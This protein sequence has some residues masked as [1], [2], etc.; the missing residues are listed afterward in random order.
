VPTHL[1][2]ASYPT[3][4][5]QYL[6][7][8]TYMEIRRI[9]AMQEGAAPLAE[10]LK[11]E[12]D[13]GKRVLWLV[14]GGSNI[15]VSAAVM[16]QISAH[17]SKNVS[18]YLTD[19]RYGEID[20]PDSNTR[21]LRE[22]GFDFKDARMVNVLAHGLGL[23]QTCEQYAMSI[24]AAFDAAQIVIAQMG[25]GP[26]GHIC[27]ILPGSPAVDSKKLVV[28]YVTETFTRITLTPKALRDHVDAAYVF[29]FGE[30]KREA[31]SNL[32]KDLPLDT[33]PAQIL[34]KLP[35]AIVYNDQFNGETGVPTT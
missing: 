4:G 2:D 11:K 29:A 26:D 24:A 14:P 7:Y 16:Q 6:V 17:Q 8:Y 15:P 10:R 9:S 13:A 19:E 27:G 35:E 33:Q 1:I 22:A 25:M 31:L 21:Q 3:A 23:E 28:G 12:L 18:I 5:Q 32:L 20:H 30:A 34:K